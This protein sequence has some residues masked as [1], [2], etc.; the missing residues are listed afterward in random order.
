MR[1]ENKEIAVDRVPVCE[2]RETE[3]GTRP[4]DCN[5]ARTWVRQ[6]RWRWMGLGSA[7]A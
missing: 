6:V 4:V 3:Q 5:G 7:V 2:V 1:R